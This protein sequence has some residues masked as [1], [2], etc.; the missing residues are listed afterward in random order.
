M[1]KRAIAQIENQ[2]L[3]WNVTGR[4]EVGLSLQPG[5]DAGT[6]TICP[7][8]LQLVRCG[9]I[10]WLLTWYAYPRL[11]CNAVGSAYI[12]K[13]TVLGS[14]PACV[15]IIVY[16]VNINLAWRKKHQGN[17][18]GTWYYLLRFSRTAMAFKA[19]SCFYWITP[20]RQQSP[21]SRAV[22][23]QCAGK[24]YYIYI[25]Y[26]TLVGIER[27]IHGVGAR[28]CVF[29][30]E[31]SYCQNCLGSQMSLWKRC[32]GDRYGLVKEMS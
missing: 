6:I 3:K 21:F 31:I 5:T 17:E 10:G 18:L 30:I 12:Y 22:A 24:Y 16:E 8:K 26:P 4:Y 19:I 13:D 14:N 15:D 25:W 7:R 11:P 2:P 20:L 29:I 23:S 28:W 27:T 32:F 9:H 1:L